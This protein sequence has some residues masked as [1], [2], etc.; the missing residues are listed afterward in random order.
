MEGWFMKKFAQIGFLVLL[1]SVSCGEQGE[2][3]EAT[4][5]PLTPTS[6]PTRVVAP[7]FDQDFIVVA[8]DAPNPPF[9]LFDDFGVVD[10]FDSRVLENIAS[11]AD[12]DYELIV[13][14]YE[15]VLENIASRDGRDFDAVIANLVIPDEP[16]EGIVF[17]EPYLEVG[18]VLV[19]LADN[20]TIQSY[21]D[22]QPGMLVGVAG[23]SQAELVARDIVGVA[24]AD[25]VNH[26][27]NGVEAL[28]ALI[29]EG[30]TAV[31][32]DSTIAD[33]YTENFPE[34]LKMV[35][36]DG[37][38]AWMSHKAYGIALAADNTDLLAKLNT[39]ITTAQESG[40][41]EREVMTWLI[42]KDTLEPG[43]SRV[44]TPAD[45]LFIGILGNLAD[46]DPASQSDLIGW[47]V[48]NNTMSGLLSFNSN[49]EL[50]PMLAA[51]MPTISE[52]GLEYTMTLRRNL[53]FPDGSELTADDVKWS[54]DRA[55]DLG[56]FNVNSVL[57][58]SDGNFY[59][60]EDAV[61]IIDPYTVKFVLQEP[62]S[63]FPA[64]L[65][66]PPYFPIS[67]ECFAEG[68][69]TLST[70]G[71][72]GP[73]S[74]VDWLPGE[75]M[76]LRANP[77]WP[78]RP[79]PAFANITL[80]FYEDAASIRRSLEE[81]SSIDMAW[82]GLPFSDFVDLQARDAN[83]DNQPDFRP[84][85]GPADFKSYLMF[86][87]TAAP[88][89]SSLVRQAVALALNRESLAADTFA[90]SRNPLYSPV[91]DAVPGH[92]PTLPQRDL[93]QA[94]AFL[95]QAGYSAET[96]LEIELWYVNDGRYSQ[97]EEAYATAIKTQLEETGVFQV[98]LNSAP[99]EQFRAQVGECAYPAYLLGWPAPGRPVDYLD[100]M[101][102]TE[103]F[104][105]SNS[106]CSNYD[107]PVMDELVKSILE[108]TDPTA[109]QTLYQQFQEKW[110]ADLPTLDILQQ[111][112]HA[113]SLPSINNVR[114]D[115]LGLLH[116]EALTKGGG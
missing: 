101:S 14:P 64:M 5:V 16:P 48:K 106:F 2:Q 31:I 28:Q 32:T 22:I 68:W 39:A 113:I 95:Q 112:T 99:F 9:A 80:R 60:D 21:Q 69:D 24:D 51:S 110:A 105:T 70:C 52:D 20:E 26:F 81:F 75:R 27:E 84:W 43:E 30:V 23:G 47:E 88:W 85:T 77:E 1:L 92:V 40:D 90:N 97:I 19:V 45:E 104:V 93:T 82:R 49:N 71:G 7:A 42:P 12:L 36:G 34:Q 78:G 53:R 61:Q 54:V 91:P 4:A 86:N 15:G 116:Y 17:T 58:D 18:Q 63:H 35:G 55:R 94:Q 41:I 44:G 8:T 109:R 3:T 76:T 59:A 89:D 72:I 11:D 73:Y 67:N 65:A 74:I 102:W 57:K 50:V 107:S 13:T 96:P 79:S 10:G 33:F 46:M 25:L 56:N 108:E 115:A 29:D 98:T 111:P 87:H 103:F 38:D 100:V 6:E 62:T 37:R 66:T 83:G 114:I